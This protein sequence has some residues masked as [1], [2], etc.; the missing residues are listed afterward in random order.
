MA[1]GRSGGRRRDDDSLIP[2][3]E[4]RDIRGGVTVSVSR[5]RDG[6]YGVTVAGGVTA[7]F[8][9]W[10]FPLWFESIEYDSGCFPDTAV[11]E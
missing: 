2:D 11:W 5:N 7:D 1:T 4:S 9:R 6:S 8:E 3:G 10:C